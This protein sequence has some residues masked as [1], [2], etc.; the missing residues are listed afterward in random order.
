MD[1]ERG[2]RCWYGT[3]LHGISN[4]ASMQRIRITAPARL[5]LGFLNLRGGAGRRFGSLGL[6]LNAPRTR[7]EVAR[8]GRKDVQVTGPDA[9][10]VRDVARRIMGH[11]RLPGGV[12]IHVLESIPRHAGLGSGTQL[13]LAVGTAILRLYGHESDP[14]GLAV[15]LG[16]GQRSGIGVGAFTAGGFLVDGGIAGSGIPPILSRLPFPRD[17]GLLL[18]MDEG[19]R[20]LHGRAERDFFQVDLSGTVASAEYLCRLC[21][22]RLLPALAEADCAAF[23]TALNTLQRAMS[24][25]FFAAQGGA[26][27]SARVG[28]VLTWLRR[29]AGALGHGQSSWGPTGFALFP[30]RAAMCR[31]HDAA[32]DY[33]G[34]TTDMRR[35]RLSRVH[36]RNLGAVVRVP[37]QPR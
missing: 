9:V 4:P 2:S 24:R 8:T 25:S 32:L 6:T 7:L 22:M 21:L 13:T 30:S 26:Y 28:R 35:L 5:H 12:A 37:R 15:V 17:W 23:G 27:T 29:H 18:V 19:C 11:A 36:G 10:L 33:C 3:V 31:A 20:G 34:K 16:R 1:H 14:R